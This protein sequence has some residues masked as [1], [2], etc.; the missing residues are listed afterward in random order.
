MIQS[1]QP[2]V[3]HGTALHE[4]FCFSYDRPNCL[5]NKLAAK[6]LFETASKFIDAYEEQSPW[7]AFLSFTDSHED[8][9]SMVQILDDVMYD[10]IASLDLSKTLVVLL[11][12][13]GLHY[14]PHFQTLAGVKE[15]AQPILY[16]HLPYELQ[17][18]HTETLQENSKLWTSHFDVHETFLEVALEIDRDEN[19][20]VIGSSLLHPF[21]NDRREC[22]GVP[23][24]PSEYC[25]MV[26]GNEVDHAATNCANIPIPPSP[27]TFLA[28][29]PR[30]R[31]PQMSS[32]KNITVS[33][34]ATSIPLNRS[35]L[36]KNSRHINDQSME[37]GS[38][39]CATDSIGWYNC[40]RH[41]WNDGNQPKTIIGLTYCEGDGHSENAGIEVDIRIQDVAVSQLSATILADTNQFL[42]RQML[43]VDSIISN[44]GL[45]GPPP[46]VSWSILS[47]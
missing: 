29:L 45:S 31:Q 25:D 7:A 22:H 3:T 23:G 47:E 6:H 11:S 1:L 9:H 41:P 43:C 5:G 36:R 46:P 42:Q 26:D 39:K 33:Q 19:P 12:D 38:C 32:C 16:M 21:P 27:L 17:N 8:S 10:F 35:V 15:R 44:L 4:M 18:R 24:I 20:D 14:G 30:H 13:H 2:N 28:D 34:A 37:T 40:T